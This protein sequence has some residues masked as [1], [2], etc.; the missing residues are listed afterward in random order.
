MATDATDSP[1]QRVSRSNRERPMGWP[2]LQWPFARP[3]SR[4]MILLIWIAVIPFACYVALAALVFFS[5]R[6][7]MYFPERIHT[8]PAAA[9]LP[10][11]EE[12]SLTASDRGPHHRWGCD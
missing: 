4:R 6:S 2:S 10:E 7:L 12:V 3:L 9:G 1:A 5:Q 8:T 11:A